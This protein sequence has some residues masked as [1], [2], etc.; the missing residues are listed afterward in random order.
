[1][2]VTTSPTARLA[3]LERRA[4]QGELWR[5]LLVW[6]IRS[7]SSSA[8]RAGCG[9]CVRA[10][11]AARFSARIRLAAPWTRCNTGSMPAICI[12]GRRRFARS[13]P[14][15]HWDAVAP[16]AG[17]PGAAASWRRCLRAADLPVKDDLRPR[18]LRAPGHMMCV[19]RDAAREPDRPPPKGR[20]AKGSKDPMAISTCLL[21]AMPGK[22]SPT[23]RPRRRADNAAVNRPAEEH[24]ET[25]A[26]PRA[27]RPH[28]VTASTGGQHATRRSAP[29][30]GTKPRRSRPAGLAQDALGAGCVASV[31]TRPD[32]LAR[33]WLGRAPVVARRGAEH[34]PG[35]SRSGRPGRRA[36][37]RG[38]AVGTGRCR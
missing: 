5:N 8:A 32:D 14:A 24:H 16:R 10:A 25:H 34:R 17:L 13:K 2:K 6:I 4:G 22:G 20:E 35:R 21:R 15:R 29:N 7:A 30:P 1:M 23:S 31:A 3:A 36:R 18:F 33:L 19:T 27:P 9:R 11:G 26:T 12:S 38:R 28:F 37:A